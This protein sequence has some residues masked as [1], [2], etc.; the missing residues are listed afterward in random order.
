MLNKAIFAN[1][2]EPP[3]KE[4]TK[5][6]RKSAKEQAKEQTKIPA[7]KI[8][9]FEHLTL[10]NQ[11][12]IDT[13]HSLAHLSQQIETELKQK[14]IDQL[15]TQVVEQLLSDANIKLNE[16]AYKIELEDLFKKLATQ[17][18]K[19]QQIL[20]EIHHTYNKYEFLNQLNQ[21]AENANSIQGFK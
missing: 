9:L 16:T 15:A 14:T 8:K 21:I 4:S 1:M 7:S 17:P 12:G 18:N 5:P 10:K 19:S 6:Q 13:S 3:L 2:Q 11:I 20:E